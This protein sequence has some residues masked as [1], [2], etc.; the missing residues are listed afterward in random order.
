MLRYKPAALVAALLLSV[1]TVVD[2]DSARRGCN[3]NQFATLDIIPNTTDSVL[4]PVQLGDQPTALAL[5]T[6]G[7]WGVLQSDVAAGLARHKA[8]FQVQGAAGK[9]MWRY[10]EVPTLQIGALHGKDVQFYVGGNQGIDKSKMAGT[11]GANV[12]SRYDLE[13]DPRLGKV[14][15]F[16][17]NRCGG[18]LAYWNTADAASLSFD[19][20][21][22]LITLPVLLDG[23]PMRALLDTGATVSMLDLDTAQD[24]F[25]LTPKSAGVEEAG[26]STALSGQTLR[27]YSYRFKSLQIGGITFTNPL[28]TLGK[29]QIY[30]IVRAQMGVHAPQLILGMH[31]LRMLHIYIAYRDH[32]LY[33]SSIQSDA[34]AASGGG[35]TAPA[36]PVM[37]D[38]LDQRS[39]QK[40]WNS[41]RTHAEKQEYDLA[42]KDLDRAI[43]LAP[44]QAALYLGRANVQIKRKAYPAAVADLDRAI[45]LD[46]SKADVY[47]ERAQAYAA[48]KDTPHALADIDRTLQ[49]DPSMPQAHLQRAALYLNAGDAEKALPDLD[50]EIK[51]H[52]DST[53][54]RAARCWTLETLRRD[55][56]ALAACDA[57]VAADADDVES[58]YAR[59]VANLNLHHAAA[60]IRDYTAVLQH[61][62]QR[63]DAL[64]G[65]GLAR[66]Q[67]GD[68][69]GAQA[70]MAAAVRL[71]PSV[72]RHFTVTTKS[73]TAVASGSQH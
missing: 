71:D 62:P 15:F 49:L 26:S 25:G 24:S 53:R 57:A 23:K 10:V 30:G 33:L 72:A 17:H 11:L 1:T 66:R 51:L 41:A 4:V 68:A 61:D 44:D 37:T 40:L 20:D 43:E 67:S 38:V 48:M 28:L 2:A 21:D 65:R 46:G 19:L 56:A 69:A 9:A 52:P 12:L 70:D 6:G 7:V 64:Y 39:A 63:A 45:A 55:Q 31:E 18:N 3:L 14:N 13:I 42:L 50:Q 36:R 47:F 27:M 59:A 34:M 58:Q 35:A 22:H 60:A 73:A 8:T 5:D 32:K 54:A 16:E 29:S